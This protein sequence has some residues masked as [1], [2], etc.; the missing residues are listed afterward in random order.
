M[1]DLNTVAFTTTLL[2]M[3]R[4]CKVLASLGEFCEPARNAVQHVAI[5]HQLEKMGKEEG[6][7][8][9][10]AQFSGNKVAFDAILSQVISE[11]L[12]VAGIPESFSRHID[13]SYAGFVK[14]LRA[15]RATLL[16]MAL[17]HEHPLLLIELA[18]NGDRRAV[19]D[20]IKVD[21]M[22]VNDWCCKETIRRAG[23][24]D[25]IEFI[26][27]VQRA[28]EYKRKMGRREIFHVYLFHLFL[29][30]SFGIKASPLNELWPR[31]D[32]LGREYG[33]LDAFEKDVQRRRDNFNHI[34]ESGK[35]G[36]QSLIQARKRDQWDQKTNT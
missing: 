7:K 25:D 27:Q 16:C 30:E 3:T 10:Q 2:L 4:I 29:F 32:P 28:L 8:L 20:L 21:K 18:S 26:A 5:K 33:S 6:P 31:L 14:L 35:L 17:L 1:H 13:K 34:V 36:A 23:L 11:V 19:L 12:N 24:Q 9:R 15:T 22:F